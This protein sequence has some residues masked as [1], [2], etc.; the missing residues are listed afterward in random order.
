MFVVLPEDNV[1]FDLI[2]YYNKTRL[3]KG[4]RY[5]AMKFDVVHE[6]VRPM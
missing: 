2:G 3:G 1:V 4:W 6:M 5:G